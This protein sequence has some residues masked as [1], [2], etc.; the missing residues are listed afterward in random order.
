MHM[1]YVMWVLRGLVAIAAAAVTV[2]AI[3]GVMITLEAAPWGGMSPGFALINQTMIVSVP[4]VPFGI[5]VTALWPRWWPVPVA[6]LLWTIA[7]TI[8]TDPTK[9]DFVFT[10]LLGFSG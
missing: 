3:L 8:I 2:G 5:V 7:A 6:A 9:F 10:W 4:L 1:K